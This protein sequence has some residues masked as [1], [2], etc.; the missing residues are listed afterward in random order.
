M[1]I[2][3]LGDVK[4][5]SWAY[6]KLSLGTESVY[7][8][9]NCTFPFSLTSLGTVSNFQQN[10]AA[11]FWPARFHMIDFLL[12]TFI[13]MRAILYVKSEHLVQQMHFNFPNYKGL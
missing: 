9:S 3:V 6:R 11:L 8:T 10:R 13:A 1:R 4:N 5:L 7:V 2:H 12:G